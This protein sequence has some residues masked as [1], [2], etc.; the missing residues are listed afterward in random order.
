VNERLKLLNDKIDVKRRE[1]SEIFEA[2]GDDLK[3]SS[4]QV[5]EVKQRNAEI[6]DLSRE[7]ETLVTTEDIGRKNR[8]ALEAKN[9]VV[10][11]PSFASGA[12][13]TGAA[14]RK[15]LGQLWLESKARKD[16]GMKFVEAEVKT[17]MATSNGF[18]PQAVR[19]GQVIDLPQEMPAMVDII[20]NTTTNE[21]AVVFMREDTY[22]SGA[23]EVAEGADYGESAFHFT[24]VSSPVRK[25]PVFVPVTDEQLA[26]ETGM[27]ERL[28]NRL[29]LQLRQR[30][31]TQTINGDGTG[32]NLVGFLN[33]SG[34]LTQAKA[35]DINIDAL[36]KAITKQRIQDKTR[37]SAL[38]MHPTDWQNIR[39]LRTADGLYIFGSPSDPAP[40]RVWGLPVV[41]TTEIT[42]GTA[43]MGDFRGYSELAFK[44]G[45]EFEVSN[46][47]SDYFVKGIQAIRAQLR[48]A[49]V[50]LRP[51]AFVEITGL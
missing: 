39:L 12:S 22:T 51:T 38:V 1:L 5:D 8:E 37:P 10:N 48:V 32:Q 3:M 50:V 4:D 41:D 24:E 33:T 34:I 16:T 15:T 46:S 11:T 27:M 36:Y 19:T 7:R 49:L 2:A 20:P 23:A 6:E 45:I 30:L 47:H 28:D 40:Q 18:A 9:A 44:A 31:D 21:V 35:S 29:D 25:I 17:L 42:Q 26:D 14:E 13:D 43:L